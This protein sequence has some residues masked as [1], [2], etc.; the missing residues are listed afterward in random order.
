MITT[1]NNNYQNIMTISL[2]RQRERESKT[3]RQTDRQRKKVERNR[4]IE[5]I[6][7]TKLHNL[8]C[9]ARNN[10]TKPADHHYH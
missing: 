5:R 7:R 10:K 3:E 4:W 9:K 8:K 2:N 6:E 1:N